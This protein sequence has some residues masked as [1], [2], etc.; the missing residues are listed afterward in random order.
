M[1]ATKR[2][3]TKVCLVGDASVGKTCLI[4]RFVLNS[5]EDMYSPTIG[6]KISK[7][8]LEL[9]QSEMNLQLLVEMTIWDIMGQKGFRDL[10]KEA[11]FHGA[12]GIVAVCDMTKRA[13]L[14]SLGEWL[15]SV[16]AVTGRIPVVLIANKIDLMESA[17][18]GEAELMQAA[19]A[20]E[21][22]HYLSSAKTG[23]NVETA[24]RTL[25]KAVAKKWLVK[26]QP[27]EA[28]ESI[29]IRSSGSH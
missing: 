19:E 8:E 2:M 7:M 16:H 17:E 28:E 25:A 12:S 5:F 18:F 9:F 10:L 20:Y 14:D 13:T 6:T 24:F 15:E 22:P 4:R 23:E 3:R 26:S 11:Y 27:V 21:S 1:Q 29:S